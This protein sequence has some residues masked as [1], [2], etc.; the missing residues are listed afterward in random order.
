MRAT[1]TT[2]AVALFIAGCSGGGGTR[3]NTEI[4]R[5]PMPEG[6][7]WAGVYF[8]SWGQMSLSAQGSAVVGEFCDEESNRYGRLEGTAQGNVFSFHWVT[9]DVTMAGSPR[10]SEGSGIVQFTFLPA[11]ESQQGHFEGTWGFERSNADGGPLRGDR[12]SRYSDRFLRGVY[13]V[14]CA[15]REEAEVGPPLSEEDVGDN[16]DPAAEDLMDEGGGEE[17]SDGGDFDI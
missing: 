6:G 12:S 9:T 4:Q 13:T 14:P 5:G 11:G 8:S 2:L 7:S 10:T 3:M 17:S 1:L 16:P 15:L